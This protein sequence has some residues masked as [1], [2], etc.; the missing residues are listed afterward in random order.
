MAH[1]RIIRQNFF[2]HPLIASK[3][4]IEERYFLIGLASVADDFGRFWYNA[5]NIKSGIFPTDS[6]INADWINK[7]LQKITDDLI[8]CIYEVDGTLYGHFPKWFNKGWFLKQRLDH[9]REYASPDCPA[10]MIETRKRESSRTI[11]SK[12]N[13][14]NKNKKNITQ[15]KSIDM[16]RDIHYQSNMFKKYPL[17]NKN[18]YA[19]AL[20]KYIHW[21]D[22]NN[23]YDKNHERE[24][25]G[26]LMAVQETLNNDI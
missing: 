20:E 26:R 5:D 16:L 7:C 8:L 1:A 6:K 22:N 14:A 21:V 24:F 18:E 23:L 2:N 3:Y 13:K 10:C 12:P 11:K 19:S 25:E 15:T 9:P 17:I 4:S